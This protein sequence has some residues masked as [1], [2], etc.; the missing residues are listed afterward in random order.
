MEQSAVQRVPAVEQ[1][2]LQC[3]GLRKGLAA[4]EIDRTILAGF[5]NHVDCTVPA[6][7]KRIGKVVGPLQDG[8]R[9]RELSVGGQPAT[10]NRPLAAAL[11]EVLEQQM[12]Y[13]SFLE[14][15]GIGVKMTGRRR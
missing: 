5:G 1:R 4:V 13:S 7:H 11:V 9:S 2:C 10:G 12:G 6:E 15:E 3:P 14:Q 8:L